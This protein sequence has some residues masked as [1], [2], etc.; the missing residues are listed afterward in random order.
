MR[1]TSR[2]VKCRREEHQKRLQLE[3]DSVAAYDSVATC[4]RGLAFRAEVQ[5]VA[6][7]QHAR[8]P[9]ARCL[10]EVDKGV[11][12]VLSPVIAGARLTPAVSRAVLSSTA[13]DTAQCRA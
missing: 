8:E 5:A 12:V 10:T 6:D 3:Y 2:R 13:G 7:L 4:I 9:F 1:D 11:V